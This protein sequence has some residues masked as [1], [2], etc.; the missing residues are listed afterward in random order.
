MKEGNTM[1]IRA[2]NKI[3]REK[4]E[5]QCSG[6]KNIFPATIDYFS[7]K[8]G[9]HLRLSHLCINCKKGVDKSYRD[10]KR[11]GP[12]RKKKEQIKKEP[13]EKSYVKDVRDAR[14]DEND[15]SRQ[16][17]AIIRQYILYNVIAWTIQEPHRIL[18]FQD[19]W[20]IFYGLV[21]KRQK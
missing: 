12:P 19:V 5:K 17:I 3:L 18:Q 13:V 11:G 20:D 9:K 14:K 21:Y 6:C 8:G 15:L 2:T 1:D 16:R 4:G 10:K 7:N